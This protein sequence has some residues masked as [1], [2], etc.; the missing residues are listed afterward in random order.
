MVWNLESKR[1]ELLVNYLSFENMFLLKIFFLQD[2]LFWLN[3][4]YNDSA[5][6]VQ[7]SILC[8]KTKTIDSLILA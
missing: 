8:S 6:S 1:V 5:L 4:W 2:T 7:F 3:N